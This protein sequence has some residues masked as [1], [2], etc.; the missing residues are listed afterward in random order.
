MNVACHNS[1][2]PLLSRPRRNYW[3]ET[4]TPLSSLLFLIPG[5][6]IYEA[7]AI[8]L[9][10]SSGSTMRNGADSWMRAALNSAGLTGMLLPLLV[11]SGL[12]AW[13]TI[14]KDP[15]KPRWKIQCGMLAESVALAVVLLLTGQLHQL[16]FLSLQSGPTQEV[17]TTTLSTASAFTTPWAAVVTYFG[18][19]IYEEVLFRL[20][21][22]PVVFSIL[23]AFNVARRPAV[24]GSV[25]LTALAFAAA[26][27]VGTNGEAFDAIRFTFRAAA[28]TFFAVVFYLRG[29]GIT[30]G[31]HTAYDL[32]VGVL[33]LAPSQ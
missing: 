12:L 7:G 5:L 29:F 19:G 32:L 2:E 28:G 4:S 9:Q 13:H 3:D 10:T 30:V 21:L 8:L 31:C 26:H 24:A 6:L 11:V 14:R 20:L 1:P 25:A 15:W 18:A 23:R 33:L 22:V 27:H 17:A 16:L